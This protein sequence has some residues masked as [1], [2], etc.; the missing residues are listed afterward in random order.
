MARTK[1]AFKSLK[2]ILLKIKLKESKESVKNK[3]IR[4]FKTNTKIRKLRTL[5]DFRG[6]QCPYKKNVNI[7]NL[8]ISHQPT[9]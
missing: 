2:Y 5:V 7:C 8:L 9:Q 4:V 3:N 6:F 1:Q